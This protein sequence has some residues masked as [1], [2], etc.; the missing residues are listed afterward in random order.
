MYESS[1]SSKTGMQTFMF[2]FGTVKLKGVLKNAFL[3][4][5]RRNLQVA[6]LLIAG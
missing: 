1:F 2:A 4:F 3:H 5:G 6:G